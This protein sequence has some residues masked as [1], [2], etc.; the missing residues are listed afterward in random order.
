MV[1]LEFF[2]LIFS[3]HDIFLT[4]RPI[5][6]F[7]LEIVCSLIIVNLLNFST[8]I[9]LSSYFILFSLDI[10]SHTQGS[11]QTMLIFVS[12][13]PELGFATLNLQSLSYKDVGK[14]P[15]MRIDIANVYT[16][17][18]LI[19]NCFFLILLQIFCFFGFFL[20]GWGINPNIYTTPNIRA[21]QHR[22]IV[23]EYIDD[24]LPSCCSDRHIPG[25]GGSWLG[26]VLFWLND[27][28]KKIKIE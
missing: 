15:W 11:T 9:S 4:F 16:I 25:R 22:C 10:L 23:Q 20:R 13:L 26:I 7:F 8:Q 2:L 3:W 1:L 27:S 12:F 5:S 18:Y 6:D 24:K 28:W 17:N 21:G 14:I 19:N